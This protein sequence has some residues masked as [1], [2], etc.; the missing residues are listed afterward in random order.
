VA[1]VVVVV[2]VLALAGGIG[3]VYETIEIGHGGT[4]ATGDDVGPEGTGG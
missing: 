1:V 3:S 2:V 4:T